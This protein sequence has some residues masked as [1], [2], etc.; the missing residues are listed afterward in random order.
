MY[1]RA[2]VQ[3]MAFHLKNGFK[4]G[5]NLFNEWRRGS[6]LSNWILRI[7]SFILK[8][9]SK[10]IVKRAMRDMSGVRNDARLYRTQLMVEELGETLEGMYKGDENL[11][12]DGLGDLQYVVVGSA[13]T[14]GIP[15]Q[16]VM[17]EIQ[18]AN[19]SKKTRT[20]K[21]CRMRNKGRDWKRPDIE[22]AIRLGRGQME[23]LN[24][25]AKEEEMKYANS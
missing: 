6:L 8:F 25:A 20:D 10:R 21:D 24:Q 18:R 17:D 1:S 13:V 5:D 2:E 19:M 7:I 22:T 14:N 11:Y 9:I 15:L 23:S 12:A 4:V 3:V 16:F